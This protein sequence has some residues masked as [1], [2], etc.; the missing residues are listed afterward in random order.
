M[1]E[2]ELCTP[3]AEEMKQTGKYEIKSMEYGRVKGTC[4]CCLLRRY[5]SRY[6]VKRVYLKGVIKI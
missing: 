4:D 2:M 3:C 1:K 6:E 5:V